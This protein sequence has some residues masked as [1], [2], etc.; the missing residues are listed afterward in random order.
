DQ[1]I[2]ND[3][4][5]D[6]SNHIYVIITGIEDQAEPKIS[7]FPNPNDG[8]FI[9]LLHQQRDE[10]YLLTVVNQL[11]MKVTEITLDVRWGRSEHRIDLRPLPMGLY[12]ILLTSDS[13]QVVR[14]IIVE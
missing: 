8:S 6:T 9:L 10:T 4:A 2:I 12:T 7:L 11:G 5:S 1:V 3:C 13:R 14:K